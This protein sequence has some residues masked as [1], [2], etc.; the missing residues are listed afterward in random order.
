MRGPSVFDNFPFEPIAPLYSPQSNLPSLGP[1]GDVALNLMLPH[2]IRG[3][4]AP[5]YYGRGNLFDALQNRQAQNYYELAARQVAQFDAERVATT[6]GKLAALSGRDVTVEEFERLKRISA[7]IL[8][9]AGPSLATSEFGQTI[10]DTITGGRSSINIAAHLARSGRT[11]YDVLT[12][13]LGMSDL[14]LE[15][16]TREISDEFLGPNAFFQSRE[17]GALSGALVSS[18][19]IVSP[20]QDIIAGRN[21]AGISPTDVIAS[22]QEFTRRQADVS[23]LSLSRSELSQINQNLFN[24]LIK[25]VDEQAVGRYVDT[26]GAFSLVRDLAS[27]T[28][29]IRNDLAFGDSRDIAEVLNRVINAP[30][31]ET[32]RQELLAEVQD[33]GQGEARSVGAQLILPLIGEAAGQDIFN[34][35]LREED[36]LSRDL[37]SEERSAR[38][39][40]ARLSAAAKIADEFAT[41]TGQQ[42]ES[43]VAS[44]AVISQFTNLE[45]FESLADDPFVLNQ[46]R[47]IEEANRA[48]FNED[49][50]IKRLLEDSNTKFKESLGNYVDML[51]ALG[52]TIDDPDIRSDVGKLSQLASALGIDDF[53]LGGVESSVAAGTRYMRVAAA[54]GLDSQD[55]LA[56]SNLA[57]QLARSANLSDPTAMVLPIMSAMADVRAANVAFG[58]STNLRLGDASSEQLALK[59][60]LD[61]ANYMDSQALGTFGAFL[62]LTD[63]Y[64][65]ENNDAGQKIRALRQRI[66]DRNITDEDALLLMDPS[67]LESLTTAGLRDVTPEIFSIQRQLTTLNQE[68]FMSTQGAREV[69]VRQIALD[70][71]RPFSEYLPAILPTYVQDE[72]LRKRFSEVLKSSNLIQFGPAAESYLELLGDLTEDEQRQFTELLRATEARSGVNLNDI[73]RSAMAPDVYESLERVARIKEIYNT[74]NSGMVN[75]F[76]RKIG[77]ADLDSDS[78]SGILLKSVG[79]LDKAARENEAIRTIESNAEALNA[80]ID[81]KVLEQIRDLNPEL[82]EQFKDTRSFLSNLLT[83]EDRQLDRDTTEESIENYLT[84]YNRLRQQTDYLITLLDTRSRE[85]REGAVAADVANLQLDNLTL[86]DAVFNLTTDDVSVIVKGASGEANLSTDAA[87]AAPAAL[88]SST[89]R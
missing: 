39:A 73:F 31:E 65:I 51:S 54:I 52:R 24:E 48:F 69:S 84:E 43:L 70:Q 82:S 85:L 60:G 62:Y 13:Q 22:Q 71:V 19:R 50:T 23:R 37:P 5:L 68:R 29:V 1:I 66:L 36:D 27:V 7:G 45:G 10:L 87:S 34:E 64:D 88:P 56:E 81:P 42:P 74:P 32:L 86:S 16:L 12:G 6:A 2:L 76:I 79:V 14:R 40:E 21:I 77:E 44:A 59:A 33:L 11:S 18:G 49:D 4:G 28:N 8:S 41:I 30:D 61:A 20:I 3:S 72:D 58:L 25:D 55:I 35:Y 80:I 63:R 15:T 17:L 46:L 83:T 89:S 78:L 75:E 57:Q 47:E 53:K 26:S 9:G 67:G 38:L